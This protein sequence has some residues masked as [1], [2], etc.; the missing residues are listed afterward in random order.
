MNPQIALASIGGSGSILK[1]PLDVGEDKI[2]GHQHFMIISEYEYTKHNNKGKDA[3]F[4]FKQATQGAGSGEG[5]YKSV[6]NYALYLPAGSIKTQYSAGHSPTDF[7]FFGALLNTEAN[8]IY[9]RLTAGAEGES[10]L[11][12]YTRAGS[13]LYEELSPGIES[14]DF[15]TKFG[16]NIGQAIGALALS[17]DAEKAS[18]IASVSMRK[19]ANPY[20]TL[21]FTGVK[22]RRQHDFAFDFYPRNDKESVEILKIINGLKAG[23]LP[24]LRKSG[25]IDKTIVEVEKRISGGPLQ[26][27]TY[28][29][30]EERTING[31]GLSSAFFDYPRVFRINFFK[32][33]GKKNEFLHKIGQSFITNLKVTYGEGEVQSFFKE[34]GAPTHVKLDISFKEN[35]A[36]S[37]QSV[38]EGF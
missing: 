14:Y 23:M 13:A 6:N 5:F 29:A 35:F 9:K 8:D 3:L 38:E 32:K 4:N 27:M 25:K 7:G 34:T 16:F 2:S 22:T 20:T 15:K 12:F 36:L 11:D 21:V 19:Q 31:G 28:K 1:Y 24:S 30:K 33:G 26:G 17:G 10:A 18:S 37:R